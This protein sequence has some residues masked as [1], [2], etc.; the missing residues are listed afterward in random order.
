M[1]HDL[2]TRYFELTRQRADRRWKP[3]TL[4]AKVAELEENVRRAA[5][6]KARREKEEAIAEEMRQSRIAARGSFEEFARKNRNSEREDYARLARAVGWAERVMEEHNRLTTKLSEDFASDPLRTMEWGMTYVAHAADY[7]VANDL[8]AMFEHGTTVHGMV[9]TLTRD[10][11][12]K[13]SYPARSTN[14]MSNLCE[15]E[16]LRAIN[17]LLGYLD[18]SEYF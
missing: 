15:Q 17:K 2:E 7:Q 12:H 9:S 5:A 14:P 4:A 8:K 16:K 11:R 13:A 18:G 1:T 10:L 6:E 3:A